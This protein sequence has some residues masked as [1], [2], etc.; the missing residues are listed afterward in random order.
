MKESYFFSHDYNA[1]QDPK[2]QEV[3]MDYGVAGIGI[4]WCII[5][6]LYEQGGRMPLSSIKAIAFTLHANIEDVQGIIDNSGL[7]ENDGVEFWSPSVSRRLET[8]KTTS[9]KKSKAA[10]K[11]WSTDADASKNNASAMQVHQKTMQ[12]HYT[13]DAGAMQDCEEVGT[14]QCYKKKIKEKEI[15]ENNNLS[16]TPSLEDERAAEPQ[17]E[18]EV[19]LE[20]F[21]FR[22]FRSPVAEVDRFIAHYQANGWCRNGS[23]RP[24]KD[25]A[26]LARCWE[27]LDKDY[28]KF[29]AD[30]LSKWKCLYEVAKARNT[31]C[32][33][34]LLTD[35]YK[36]EISSRE[37]TICASK[38]LREM[39]YRNADFFNSE[40][41]V[42][43]YNDKKL[44]WT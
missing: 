5:E 17:T 15:K 19:F 44:V 36:V 38:E 22:N 39:M 18:R 8:R 40:F 10:S 13:S 30:F 33:I 24:V 21:F 14:V 32:A 20:I 11:R 23:T 31:Q 2:M 37:L 6:Q 26:A 25:R 3:L 42:K 35:I 7:F 41:F 27:P 4:Y 29:P 28:Q 43:Y 34:K 1:R 9:E 12:M 16:L